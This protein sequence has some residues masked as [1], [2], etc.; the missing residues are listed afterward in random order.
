M[1]FDNHRLSP[2]LDAPLY[3]QLYRQLQQAILNGQLKPGTKLPS[4][5]AMAA[6]LNISRNTVQSAYR[7]LMDEGYIDSARGSGT[8]V[9]HKLPEA[10]LRAP[11]VDTALDRRTASRTEDP[12]PVP[13]LSRLARLQLT[14]AP[15]AREAADGLPLPFRSDTPALDLFP[16]A[17]WSRLAV[18]QARR[19]A[20][21]DLPYQDPAGYRLLREAIAAHAAIA[22]RVNCTPEQVI[23]TSGS[24]GALDLTARLLLDPGDAVW[25]ED[26]G[27]PGARLAFLGAGAQIVPV[28]LDAE[29][30]VVEAGI[31]R[32]PNARLAYL[33]PAHQFP[34]GMTLSLRRR[35]ALLDWA[36]Q[37]GA[38]LIEDDYDSEFRYA[39]RPLAALQGLDDAGRVI[40]IGTFSKVLFPALRAG[41]LILPPALLEPCLAMRRQ[42][43]VHPPLPEQMLLA[44]FISGGHFTRHLR[45]MR[46]SYAG[47]RT[48]LLEAARGLPLEIQVP[49]AGLHCIGWLP[50]EIDIQALLQT[51][52]QHR[53][54]LTP[55][56]DFC[57]EPL[58]R[59]GLLLGY[60]GF[61]A[62]EIN[63]GMRR[64][65]A[66]LHRQQ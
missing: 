48:A 47:R 35:L 9:A 64:L 26:P 22:R 12:R 62:A 19:L 55:V 28:P 5:R 7:Q 40:Y 33:T 44:D 17:L 57:I 6:S 53:L 52:P 21:R 34:L 10:L 43:D 49:T 27:Y 38:Y 54:E 63:S 56:S 18:R 42:T 32:A 31:K 65:A 41:Y 58:P 11:A 36:Q 20:P 29:G 8:Y 23:I 51:A 4:S 60:A 2:A 14:L 66:L 37:T 39:G 16:F 50:P 61:N 13:Q 45:R 15:P 25:M 46:R 3:Q 30:L 1:D 59:P 24:Q